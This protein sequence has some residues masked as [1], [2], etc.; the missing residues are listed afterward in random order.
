M[1]TIEI[2][3]D[4]DSKSKMNMI[5]IKQDEDKIKELKEIIESFYHQDVDQIIKLNSINE[6]EESIITSIINNELSTKLKDIKEEYKNKEDIRKILNK[7]NNNQIYDVLSQVIMIIIKNYN[8]LEIDIK[9]NIY[10]ENLKSLI[11]KSLNLLHLISLYFDNHLYILEHGFIYLLEKIWENY[12]KDNTTYLLNFILKGKCILR[13]CTHSNNI[14]KAILN[15]PIFIRI[16]KEIIDLNESKI[17]ILNKNTILHNDIIIIIN[18]FIISKSYE[19]ILNKI[20]INIILKLAQKVDYIILL[21]TIINI[22]IY[23]YIIHKDNE[24][25]YFDDINDS[26]CVIIESS[27]I[28]INRSPSLMSKIFNLSCIL[29]ILN[30]KNNLKINIL[31]LIESINVDIDIFSNDE[32]YILSS[33]NFLT[34]LT[35]NNFKNNDTEK[36][37]DL[38]EKYKNLELM[39]LF[40]ALKYIKNNK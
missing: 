25:K 24:Q 40:Q 26:V 22:I 39:P 37:L 18:I 30:N 8:L 31:K 9:N 4:N 20:G 35:K 16:I 5:S 17:K 29:L 11:E 36:S 34:T 14:Y 15:S 12:H 23:Y 27:T 7:T 21:E 3:I 2:I 28:N 13:E 38:I 1:S 32:Q 10:F 19:D 6:L 33:L